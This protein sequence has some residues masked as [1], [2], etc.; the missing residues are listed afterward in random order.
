M[1]YIIIATEESFG[2]R[3]ENVSIMDIAT[4]G[5]AVDYIEARLK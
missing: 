4:V 3:F 1:L 5:V 2:I